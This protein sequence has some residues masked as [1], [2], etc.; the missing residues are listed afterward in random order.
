[1]TNEPPIGLKS[2]MI[3]SYKVEPLSDSNFFNSN[4]EAATF[5]KL[6][7]GLTMFHA[8]LL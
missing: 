7:F 2:N 8:I 6:A 1:M 3:G 5:K 4:S